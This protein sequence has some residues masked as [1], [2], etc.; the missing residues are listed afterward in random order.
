MDGGVDFVIV[1]IV[2]ERLVFVNG[3]LRRFWWWGEG[4]DWGMVAFSGCIERRLRRASEGWRRD[5]GVVFESG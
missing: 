3:E 4:R 5:I 1:F 2:I